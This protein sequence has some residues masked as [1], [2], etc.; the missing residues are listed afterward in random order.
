MSTCL[1]CGTDCFDLSDIGEIRRAGRDV[2][3]SRTTLG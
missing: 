2:N 1:S 3:D